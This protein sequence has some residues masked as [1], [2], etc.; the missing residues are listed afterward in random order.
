LNHQFIADYELYLKSVRGMQHNSA[1]GDV[2]RI[3]KI[4]RQCV[5]ND[6]LNKDRLCASKGMA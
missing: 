3:K 4:V 1:M 5:T 6:W 2:K